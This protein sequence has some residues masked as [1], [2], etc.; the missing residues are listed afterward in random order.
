MVDGDGV[1]LDG[2]AA[3]PLQVHAVEDLVAKVALADGPG[4]EEELVGQ[5]AL[6]VVDVGD[7]GEVADQLRVGHASPREA[8]RAGSSQGKAYQNPWVPDR[9]AMRAAGPWV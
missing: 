1:H 6:A 5:G 3:F 9:A 7:D 8:V 4:F 2:D